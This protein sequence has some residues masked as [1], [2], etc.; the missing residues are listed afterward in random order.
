MDA[1]MK[2]DFFNQVRETV[3]GGSLTQGQV[4]GLNHIVKSFVAAGLTDMR[5]LAYMLATAYH[6][7]AHTMQPIAEYGRGK[8]H[9]YGKKLKQSRKP[10]E[11]PD[12]L[13]YGRGYVQLT[14]YENYE[15][16]GRLTGRDLL[17]RPE[18]AMDPEIAAQIMIMGMTK[19]L[20][21]GVALSRYFN[22]VA[23][24]W[25]NARKIIN[26]LDCYEKV[27]GY[28]MRFYKALI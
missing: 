22:N 7:T 4:D 3:F 21:T 16:L 18:L 20:F 1:M 10:Y 6:E 19:G 23:N 14:W 26:G 8:K 13:Y 24:D 17:N 25:Y 5:W 2:H 15:M 9:D 27:A 11:M 28:G 12:R